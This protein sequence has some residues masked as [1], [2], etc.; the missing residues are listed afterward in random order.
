MPTP[1][2]DAAPAKPTERPLLPEAL[3]GSYRP[4][5]EVGAPVLHRRCAEVTEFGHELAQ[6]IDD[7]FF[8]MHAAQGVGLAANQIGVDLQLFVYDC[9]GEDGQRHIG[10]ICN[11][12][13][14]I[15]PPAEPAAGREGC[16]SVPG[17]GLHE[18][19]RAARTVVHGQ[20]KDGN[21]LTLE[22]HGLLA[23]CFQHETDHLNGTLYI[24]HLTPAERSRAL[25]EMAAN[26][27][28]V[29]AQREAR[30]RTL[31]G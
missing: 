24:D 12:V 8:T 2:T 17:A 22:G 31:R 9:P 6:L 21:A 30:A 23:R 1:H 18:L 11:P 13:I 5:T 16:L 25:Q 28:A 4:I 14:D 3:R 19:P 27:Q 15:Q 26:H 7:M 10:H 29:S 20:D